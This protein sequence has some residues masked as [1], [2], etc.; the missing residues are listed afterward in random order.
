MLE[1]GL[2]RPTESRYSEAKRCC[3]ILLLWL[4]P[5]TQR[6]FVCGAGNLTIAVYLAVVIRFSGMM[7]S[8]LIFPNWHP[9]FGPSMGIQH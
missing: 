1:C 6:S 9:D 3:Y 4:K 7:Q 8:A 5:L 2:D